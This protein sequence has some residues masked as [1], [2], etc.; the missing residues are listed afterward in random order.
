MSKIDPTFYLECVKPTKTRNASIPVLRF[1]LEKRRLS[2]NK[3]VNSYSLVYNTQGFSSS[4]NI[5]A[6]SDAGKYYYIHINPYNNSS[7]TTNIINEVSPLIVNPNTFEPGSYYTYMI[8]CLEPDPQNMNK[9]PNQPQLY[10]TKTINMFEFGTKHHQIMY[11][12]ATQSED[13][14]MKN[15]RDFIIYAAGEMKCENDNT[16]IFNFISGTYKMKRYISSRRRKYE[17]VY[18]TYMMNSIAPQYK[19]ILFQKSVLITDDVVPLTKKELARLRRHNVPVFM[20]DTT[21]QCNRM[22]YMVIQKSGK[23]TLTNDGLQDIYKHL[24]NNLT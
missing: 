19:N 2:Y 4:K 10:I 21:E 15:K 3:I 1:P 5:D 14:F 22:K 16:L 13:F 20:F 8:A 12:L 24:S 17:E 7:Y 6:D 9:T 18:I 23:Q 11:R